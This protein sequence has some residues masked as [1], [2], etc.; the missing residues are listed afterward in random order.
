MSDKP[1]SLRAAARST[2]SWRLFVLF[3]VV[4]PVLWVVLHG[5]G[6]A[7]PGAAHLAD[8][9]RAPACKSFQQAIASPTPNPV[10]FWELARNSALLGF[11]RVALYHSGGHHG[12]LCL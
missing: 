11:G 10:D 3:I 8:P 2:R 12:G 5:P 1:I 7:R 9:A 4:F 6:P